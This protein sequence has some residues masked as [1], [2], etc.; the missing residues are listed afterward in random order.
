MRGMIVVTDGITVSYE[1][2]RGGTLTTFGPPVSVESL[3]AA[4]VVLALWME[5]SYEDRELECQR[6]H[7]VD[8]VKAS[9]RDEV[10][11]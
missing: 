4:S 10:D 11:G 5:L 1:D 3:Q 7:F 6:I 9:L 8:Q 2:G